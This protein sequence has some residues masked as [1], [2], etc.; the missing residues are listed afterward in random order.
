[1][2]RDHDL[3]LG[4]QGDDESNVGTH[5]DEVVIKNRA[6]GELD[7]VSSEPIPPMIEGDPCS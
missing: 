1:L 7:G 2:T 5:R 4:R 6:P 3:A